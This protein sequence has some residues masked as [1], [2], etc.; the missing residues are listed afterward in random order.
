MNETWGKYVSRIPK[1]VLLPACPPAWIGAWVKEAQGNLLWDLIT[2][3]E[4][5][6]QGRK[7]SWSGGAGEFHCAC[8]RRLRR[9]EQVCKDARPSG[10]GQKAALA[11]PRAL[12]RMRT[13]YTREERQREKGR[14]GAKPLGALSGAM[15]SPCSLC[16]L[17]TALSFPLR[18]NGP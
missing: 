3:T 16:C 6:R 15:A 4:E 13:F 12:G 17:R 9:P 2:R 7:G 10:C 5:I 1:P 18:E 11:R 8:R 14:P